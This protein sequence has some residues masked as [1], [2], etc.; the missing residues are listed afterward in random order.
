MRRVTVFPPPRQRNSLAAPQ[1]ARA[2]CRRGHWRERPHRRERVAALAATHPVLPRGVAR[3][4]ARGAPRTLPS[5]GVIPP[6]ARTAARPRLPRAA[7]RRGPRATARG[8]P[9]AARRGPHVRR[10]DAGLR[11]PRGPAPPRVR[12]AR[13]GVRVDLLLRP[14]AAHLRHRA[15]LRAL[16]R[17]PFGRRPRRPGGPAYPPG[18]VR[19]GRPAGLGRALRPRSRQRDERRR[20]GRVAA[21]RRRA[22]GG[23]LRRVPGDGDV[24]GDDPRTHPGAPPRPRERGAAHPPP[25]P[26]QRPRG[27]RARDRGQPRPPAAAGGPPRPA[28]L[29]PERRV[30]R[31]RRRVAAR[32]RRRV[33][34]HVRARHRVPGDRPHAAPPIRRHLRSGRRHVRCLGQR[35]GRVAPPPTRVPT[36]HR[37]AARRGGRPGSGRARRLTTR[38][39][40]SG[41]GSPSARTV[42]ASSCS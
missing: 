8:Y 3:R 30:P 39:W 37:P 16:A 13:H 28:L 34:D 40:S 19:R 18:R 17:P 27:I 5:A 4:R 7:V 25:P 9:P 6:P 38:S 32:P 33:G 41:A 11:R 20:Q 14:R 26:A 1:T 24:P 2:R 10:R 21:P 15:A 12:R 31:R 29:L 42:R 23:R 22:R 35:R 36:R